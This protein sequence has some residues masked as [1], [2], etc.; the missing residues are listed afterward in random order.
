MQLFEGETKNYS[1]DFRGNELVI[2]D[3]SNADFDQVHAIPEPYLERHRTLTDSRLP[4]SVKVK[5]LWANASL[6]QPGAKKPEGA[7]PSGATAGLLKDILVVPA[8]PVTEMDRR[9]TPT[10]VVELSKDG[11][12]VGSFLVSSYTATDQPFTVDG[13]QYGIMMRFARNYYPFSLT[14]LKATHEKYKGTE[15]PKNFASRVKVQNP[16]RNEER[17]TV[18]YMN[19]PLRYSG[20]TF[21]QYQMSAGEMAANAGA[22]ASSTFQV[23]RNPSWLTP[24]FS[25]VIIGFGLTLQFGMH[26]VSFLKRRFV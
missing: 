17:E 18:I 22:T 2:I 13:K 24:Y 19:N 1:E 25:T 16:E 26:L 10:A 21:Y 23:V 3:R 14:L 15:I 6:A 12:S 20:N 8:P 9:N 7:I 5:K 4:F 11:K